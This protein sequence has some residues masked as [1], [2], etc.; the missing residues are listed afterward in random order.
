MRPRELALTEEH[1]AF[2]ME[3]VPGGTVADL[4]VRQQLGED[5][6]CY[7]FRQLIGV[8][9][10]CAHNMVTGGQQA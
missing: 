8:L 2:V 9:A 5:F 3:H 10:Y 7:L 1:L 4:V 6:T